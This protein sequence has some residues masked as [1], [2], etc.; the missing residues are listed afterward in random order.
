MSGARGRP[1]SA[2]YPTITVRHLDTGE[3]I[4]WSDGVFVGARGLVDLARLFADAATVLP[5]SPTGPFLPAG[6]SEPLAAAVAMLAACRDRGV[7]VGRCPVV[8]EALGGDDAGTSGA[9]H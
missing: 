5:L 2:R 6:D 8:D 4:A 3:A 9:V 7:I 1:S